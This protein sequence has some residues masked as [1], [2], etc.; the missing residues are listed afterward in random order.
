M[1][2]RHRD[3]VKRERTRLQSKYD[4]AVAHPDDLIYIAMDGCDQ[5]NNGVPQ[6]RQKTGKDSATLRLRHHLEIAQV[7]GVD[8]HI[9]TYVT[10]EDIKGDPNLTVDCLQRTLK[11]EEARRGGKLPRELCLQLDNCWRENKN[12][13]VLSTCP[14]WSSG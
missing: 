8:D 12:S 6:F 10:Q 5:L 9:Y 4:R 13:Y 7:A 1:L 14:G 3:W 2:S 11:K